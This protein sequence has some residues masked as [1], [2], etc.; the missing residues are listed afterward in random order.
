MQRLKAS[1]TSIIRSIA[2]PRLK[3]KAVNSLTAIQDTFYSTKV[4]EFSDAEFVNVCRLLKFDVLNAYGDFLFN[5]FSK[6]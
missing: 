4:I 6:M 2:V 5:F 3:R 1:G